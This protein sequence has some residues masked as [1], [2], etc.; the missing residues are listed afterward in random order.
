MSVM[1]LL[2][3]KISGLFA[4]LAVAAPTDQ[5]VNKLNRLFEAAKFHFDLSASTTLATRRGLS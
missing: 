1:M 4:A 2:V 3:P 5:M